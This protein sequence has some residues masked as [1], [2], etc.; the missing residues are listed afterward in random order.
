M[1]LAKAQEVDIVKNI[2]SS[3][4]GLRNAALETIYDKCYPRI[5]SFII[6]NSG[7]QFDAKDIFQEATMILYKNIKR[8]KFNGNSS[9]LTYLY[10][11]CRNL[12]LLQLRKGVMKISKSIDTSDLSIE[13]I[14]EEQVNIQVL[15][16]VMLDL[17]EDCQSILMGF[18]YENKSM[19]ELAQIFK[20]GSEQVAKNKKSRCLKYL[21]NIISKK[22]LSYENFMQ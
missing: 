4:L 19:K 22:G 13:D 11:I 18:Y 17:K 7:S 8:G 2:L 16:N 9:V 5:E 14:K 21:T 15:K 10:S 3:D 6:K 1:Q 20:L 12:W